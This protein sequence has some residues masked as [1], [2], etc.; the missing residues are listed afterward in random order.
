MIEFYTAVTFENTSFSCLV[1]N[2]TK[3]NKI[4]YCHEVGVLTL[5][6]Y[7][8]VAS[9]G[10]RWCISPLDIFQMALLCLP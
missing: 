3:K 1:V 10:Q 8:T 7:S 9:L 6:V 5:Y 4:P 2:E